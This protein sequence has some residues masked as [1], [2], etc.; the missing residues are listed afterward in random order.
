MI[1]YVFVSFVLLILISD[2][3]L[4]KRIR[5]Y[6]KNGPSPDESFYPVVLASI[7][8]MLF[9]VFGMLEV[10]SL[11]LLVLCVLGVVLGM[12]HLYV[13]LATVGKVNLPK[14]VYDHLVKNRE[15]Y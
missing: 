7:G 4:S 11:F 10:G 5:E 1:L 8:S 2:W 12:L 3:N 14:K 15:L 13:Y 6:I 9:F